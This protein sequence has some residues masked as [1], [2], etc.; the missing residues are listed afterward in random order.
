[1]NSNDLSFSH[2]IWYIIQY[3]F[4]RNF[5]LQVSDEIQLYNPGSFVRDS[6]FLTFGTIVN[7][8]NEVLSASTNQ[9]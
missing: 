6:E 2:Q 5:D 8:F 3:F 9:L 4:V 7:I 1:M